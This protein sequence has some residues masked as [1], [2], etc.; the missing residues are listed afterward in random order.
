[1]HCNV[2]TDNRGVA[3][4]SLSSIPDPVL[5]EEEEVPDV[6]STEDLLMEEEVGSRDDS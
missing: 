5:A 4:W 1:M 6:I 2:E 3:I